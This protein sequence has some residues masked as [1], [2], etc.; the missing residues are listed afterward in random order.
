MGGHPGPPEGGERKLA[1]PTPQ[2]GERGSKVNGGVVLQEARQVALPDLA[3]L[4][5][6]AMLRLHLK[7]TGE[8][9]RLLNEFSTNVRAKLLAYANDDGII[10]PIASFGLNNYLADAWKETFTRWESMFNGA[11]RQAALIPFAY[12]AYHHRHFMNLLSTDESILTEQSAV[13][14][15]MPG[16][17]FF[18]PQLQEILD[19]ASNRVYGDGFR[20]SQR[21]WRLDEQ[22]RQ[23]LQREVMGNI[24]NSNSAWNIAQRLEQY[25]GSGAECPRWTRQRLF[26]LTKSDIAAGDQRGLLRGNPCESKGVAY[27]A[28]RLGRNEI[29]I[30][31]A[32]A[33]DAVFGR[34][35][36]IEMEQVVLSP[37]HPP[38]GCACEEI[39]S[40]GEDGEGIYPKGTIAL[41]VHVMC[42]CYKVAVLMKDADFVNQMRGW[43]TGESTWAEMDQYAS[44]LGS[45]K[46][47]VKTAVTA[48]LYRQLTLPFLTWL[49][50]SEAETD[51][52]LEEE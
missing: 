41:P 20:L 29:Q 46:Q 43:L 24:A 48:E 52:A 22:S 7:L 45:A 49:E 15:G 35:P 30:V 32:D 36:W 9:H 44:W 34:L 37:S 28:L 33:T 18:E 12:V 19:A 21:I 25:L 11:R 47:A 40:S 14:V 26:E 51:R 8:T 23:G 5:H 42:L 31:H 6:R 3:G 27:N 13:G 38:I 39:T 4:Q 17:A 1:P 10:P 16:R 2:R 50:G